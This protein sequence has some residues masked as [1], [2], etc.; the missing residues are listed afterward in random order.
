MG[1]AS[2]VLGANLAGGAAKCHTTGERAVFRR[3]EAGPMRVSCATLA[4][5]AA[6]RRGNVTPSS[7]VD[8]LRVAAVPMVNVHKPGS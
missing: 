4:R 2:I 1:A 3:P 8:L 7:R 6:T 5:R